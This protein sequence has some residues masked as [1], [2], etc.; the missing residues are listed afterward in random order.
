[1]SALNYIIPI[2]ILSYIFAKGHRIGPFNPGEKVK[3]KNLISSLL[4]F[5]QKG[6][7]VDY[8]IEDGGLKANSSNRIYSPTQV[9]LVDLQ[10]FEKTMDHGEQS[11]LYAI[12]THDG[13]KGTLV[14]FYDPESDLKVREFMKQVK[15]VSTLTNDKLNMIYFN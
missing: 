6:Y 5:C 2:A 8:K 15:V 7:I 14:D 1:M 3:I 11:I 10:Y 9:E 13:G 4:G 12:E